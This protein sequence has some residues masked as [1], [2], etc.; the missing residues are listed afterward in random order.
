MGEEIFRPV[1][2]FREIIGHLKRLMVANKEMGL[3]SPTLSPS[4][5]DYL[6]TRVSGF[7]SLED[8]RK[9]IGDCTRCKLC[10]GRTNLVF[11]EGSPEALLVF[12]GEGP[13]REEDLAGIPF[14]GEAGRLLTRIINAMGLNREEVYICNVV[15][16]RPPNNRDPEEDEIETCLPFLREQ[17][18]L[19]RPQ[20]ICTLG[21]V[22]GQALLGKEFKIT[23]EK[24]R[25]RSFMDIALMP[26]Y[27]PAY[28]L[29]N[30]S[31]KRQVWEDIK[32]V[33]KHMGLEVK[34]DA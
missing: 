21:R 27:H 16:C 10:Y 33:M 6:K 7:T 9:F 19:I 26:T 28:L 18:N 4:N 15:K 17:L 22:A 32:K 5:F 8:L 14:V 30:P 13:G 20:V 11:G 24:G 3:E 12:V 34:K 29:R 25:W 2:E 23:Q 1:E 31:A